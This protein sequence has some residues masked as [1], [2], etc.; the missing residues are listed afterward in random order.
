MFSRIK[1]TLLAGGLAALVIPA[2]GWA[3][4][5]LVQ[6]RINGDDQW[7]M[8]LSTQP[9]ND[10]FQ[11]ANGFGWAITYTATLALPVTPTGKHYSDYFI[12][13]WVQDVGGG[14]PDWLGAFKI[15][16]APNCRFDNGTVNL[17]T[18]ATSGYW[19]VTKPLTPSA[20]GPA[21]PGYPTWTTNYTPPFVQPSLVPADL[22]AN[23][24]GP[25]GLMPLIPAAARWMSDPFVTSNTEAWFQAH[26]RCKK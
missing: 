14:G 21:I 4:A 17:L 10:G 8:Y 13:V 25:W 12:N 9:N 7:K 11:F 5:T 26:I 18:D 20:G 23:G 1:S 19:Q 15:T 22:G 3:Q 6:A 16:G 24:I 2:A